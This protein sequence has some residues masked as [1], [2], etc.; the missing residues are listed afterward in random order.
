MENLMT[1]EQVEAIVGREAVDSV[2]AVNC[3]P[4]GRCG[5]NGA[6]Q[7]DE[8]CEWVASVDAVDADGEHC[9]VRAY[10]YTTNDQDENPDSIDWVV[11]G[12]EVV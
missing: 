8:L 10:Y 5:Y 4:T 2:D 1:R 3:E 12:Y 9:E 6:C 7:G 11:E